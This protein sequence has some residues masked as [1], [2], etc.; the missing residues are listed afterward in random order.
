MAMENEEELECLNRHDGK[1]KGEVGW[2]TVGSRPKAFRRCDF[3]QDVRLDQ[4]NNPN[5]ME[6]YADSVSPPSWFDPTYAGESW[7]GE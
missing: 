7:D 4:Y 5:S 6:M 2:H 3:H 1:C